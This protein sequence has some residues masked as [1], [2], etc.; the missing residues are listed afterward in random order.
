[1]ENTLKTYQNRVG[2]EE[3][4]ADRIMRI[5]LSLY[6]FVNTNIGDVQALISAF[7]KQLD[8][9]TKD[10]VLALMPS[11][12]DEEAISTLKNLIEIGKIKTVVKP[13]IDKLPVNDLA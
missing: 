11:M 8:T 13:M 5:T 6:S 10:D 1:M 9:V 4:H 3:K 2:A 7:G 12:T